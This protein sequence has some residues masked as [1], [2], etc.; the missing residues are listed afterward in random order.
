MYMRVVE[1][2]GL[3]VDGQ[4]SAQQLGELG[5]LVMDILDAIPT[6]FF[7]RLKICACWSCRLLLKAKAQDGRWIDQSDSQTP[8]DYMSESTITNS[9]GFWVRRIGGL[10]IVIVSGA[11]AWGALVPDSA[12][13]LVAVADQ[14]NLAHEK[15][16]EVYRIPIRVT[17]HCDHPILMRDIRHAGSVVGEPAS[18]R[19]SDL[20][21]QSAT[22]AVT[23]RLPSETERAQ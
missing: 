14:D 9:T 23:V 5:I 16:E 13:R 19:L 3:L 8:E 1:S 20:N 12:G 4:R 11:T 21:P 2:A 7:S 10:L 22:L 15:L 17:N 6:A 18:K